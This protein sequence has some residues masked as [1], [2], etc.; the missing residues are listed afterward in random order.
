[1]YSYQMT[2]LA[3]TFVFSFIVFAVVF[4]LLFLQK[5]YPTS[6]Y[7]NKTGKNTGSYTVSV[8]FFGRHGSGFYYDFLFTKRK[9]G[10]YR[11]KYKILDW[12]TT[13]ITVVPMGALC[14]WMIVC[15]W[16]TIT[17]YPLEMIPLFLCAIIDIILLTMLL[18][19]KKLRARLFFHK[20]SKDLKEIKT[21]N[22]IKN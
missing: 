2:E 17:K 15:F 16:D 18:N 20:F 14:I 12:F 1:M 4:L 6:I 7:K 21:S 3:I 8:W 9:N 10:K 13:L 11:L 19:N 22:N 5:K